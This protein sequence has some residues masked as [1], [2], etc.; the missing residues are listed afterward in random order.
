MKLKSLIFAL[1]LLTYNPPFS[2]GHDTTGDAGEP[3]LLHTS[4]ECY[5]DGCCR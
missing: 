1:A 4:K 2:F 3:D 5:G